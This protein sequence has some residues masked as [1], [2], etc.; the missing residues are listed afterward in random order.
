MH[1]IAFDGWSVGRLLAE[2][3]ELYEAA[4]TGVDPQLPELPIQYADYAAWQQAQL[5]TPELQAQLCYWTEQLAGELPVLSLPTDRTRPPVRTYRSDSVRFDVPA[6][7]WAG[8]KAASRAAGVTPF[9]MLLAT[10]AATLSRHAGQD[11]IVIGTAAANRSRPEVTDLIG[12]FVNTLALRLPIDHDAPFSQL[13]EV[14]KQAA[15]AAYAH[16]DVPFD[17]VVEAV[18]PP[19]DMSRSPIFQ[20][21]FVLQNMPTP[22]LRLGELSVELLPIGA[23]ALDVD[24]S[25]E[26]LELPSGVTGELKF[27]SDLFDRGSVER[28]VGHWGVVLAGVVGDPLVS[29]GSLGLL[30]EGE[31]REVLVE[32]NATGV[33]VP[34]GSG[35]VL[36]LFG[37]Q[38]V[39]SP[40]AVAVRMGDE[41]VSFRELDERS[42]RLAWHLRGV[43][44][45]VGDVVG[46]AV[47]RSVAMVV[48]LLGVWKAGGAYLPLDPG[49]P[50]ERLGF[51][52]ADSGC[53]VVV[54]SGSALS[55]LDVSGL[56]L[57]DVVGEWEEIAA[58]EGV[59]GLEGPGDLAYVIYTSGSTGVPKGVEIEHR[60]VVSF[61]GSMQVEPGLSAGDVLLAVT[62]LSFD[63]S[64]LEVFLPLVSGAQL[65]V[66]SRDEVVDGR[67]LGGLIESSGATVVQATPTTWSML[68]DSG[69]A[70]GSGL[71]VL[72]GGEAMSR[73]LA[74]RLVE[75]CGSVWNMFGPT[76]TTIWST[77]F[78]VS[79]GGV[80]PV[81]IGRPIA[82]TVCRVLD[83]AGRSGAGG[84]AG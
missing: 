81:P 74:D 78:E 53:G 36:G 7:V 9:M 32:W 15:I 41:V 1:H 77:V 20:T 80:G 25:M 69:W 5:A 35:G 29:V 33:D 62:T 18:Q 12:M 75:R 63:I 39:R 43:G 50:V 10:Y 51:M 58:A 70:G 49:F 21:M 83:R 44:V 68:L 8:M 65:V 23:G 66:A 4:V 6:D 55:G 82:N 73:E 2:I 67:L 59:G 27:S 40:D 56:R 54:T 42:D 19:R 57:V 34:S 26:L 17:R 3:E 84:G 14:V 52:V 28:L 48:V 38:V 71:K 24:L 16:Q 30:S 45:G 37:A 11:E 47:E 60:S 46:V 79:A 64:V 61:L 76:E 22:E 72:C 31:R 13:L